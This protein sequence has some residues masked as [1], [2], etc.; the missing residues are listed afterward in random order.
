M[1]LDILHLNHRAVVTSTRCSTKSL[2]KYSSFQTISSLFHLLFI[3]DSIENVY[4]AII[5]WK[6]FVSLLLHLISAFSSTIQTYIYVLFQSNSSYFEIRI[7]FSFTIDF[8][9][10]VRL[11]NGLSLI[12]PIAFFVSMQIYVNGAVL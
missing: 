12:F 1:Y 10:L 2:E 9:G 3:S 5:S 4:S 6:T 11:F 7:I 8:Y